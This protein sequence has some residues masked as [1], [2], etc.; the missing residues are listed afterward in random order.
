MGRGVAR[1]GAGGL[2]PPREQRQKISVSCRSTEYGCDV[3]YIRKR[4]NIFVFLPSG[5]GAE[6]RGGVMM[7]RQPSLTCRSWSDPGKNGGGEV[8]GVVVAASPS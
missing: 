7:S 3:L 4:L 1:G 2:G 8:R 6:G 5:A